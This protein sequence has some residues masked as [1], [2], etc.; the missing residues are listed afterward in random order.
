MIDFLGIG[1]QKAGT[2]WLWAQLRRHPRIWMPPAKELHYFDRALHYPSP[3]FLATTRLRDRLRGKTAHDRQFRRMAWAQ[4]RQALLRREWRTLRW[5][6]RYFLGDCDDCWYASL[7]AQG[8]GAVCGEITPSY[9]ILESADVARVRALVP[10]VKILF[11][12]RNP[13]ERAWSQLRFEW[14]RGRLPET[15][16]LAEIRAFLDDPAQILRSDY[17]RTLDT[18]EA[19]FPR[20]QIFTGFYDDIAACP[21]RLL[22]KVLDFLGLEPIP[23]QGERVNVSIERPM[24]REIARQLAE[25]Y[26]GELQRLSSRLGGHAE[27]WRREAE[28]VLA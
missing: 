5:N 25:K 2:T 10:Q 16:D 21:D 19:H 22:A 6:L 23:A 8:Q 11:L 9:S 17:T 26:L 24:P 20:A 14:T 13:I 18:W 28:C 15:A 4:I 27:T 12:I 3:S 1:A 7:F